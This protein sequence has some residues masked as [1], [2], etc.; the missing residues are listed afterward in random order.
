[1]QK[2]FLNSKN[3]KFINF[4]LQTTK[5]HSSASLQVEEKL[6]KTFAIWKIENFKKFVA[7]AKFW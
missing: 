7:S 2:R 4:E 3:L 5:I 6:Q 1:M